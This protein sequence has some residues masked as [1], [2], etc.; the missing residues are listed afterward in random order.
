MKFVKGN[1]IEQQ[2]ES[3]DLIFSRFL[4]KYN[5]T[6]KVVPA[7]VL[8]Y[9]VFSYCALPEANG[10]VFRYL[11]PCDG[12]VN[13]AFIHIEAFPKKGIVIEAELFSK[14]NNS[15]LSFSV[16][17]SPMSQEINTPVN[18]GDRLIIICRSE[19]SNIWIGMLWTAN[20]KKVIS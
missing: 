2:V 20:I 16:K 1:T 6:T 11:F 10:T 17:K 14:Y 3:I 9:P 8:P 12:I 4:D 13:K 15:R 7:V 5:K 19:V 18:A